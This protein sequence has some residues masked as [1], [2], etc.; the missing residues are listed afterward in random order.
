[1]QAGA[2]KKAKEPTFDTAALSEFGLKVS[3][4]AAV[5]RFAD[6]RETLIYMPFMHALE[7]TLTTADSQ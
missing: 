3:S 6:W 7:R 2:K 5:G 4:C 1:M